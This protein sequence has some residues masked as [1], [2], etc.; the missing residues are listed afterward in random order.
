[1]ARR[2]CRGRNMGAHAG[3]RPLP[4]R[5]DVAVIAV[6]VVAVGVGVTTKD[7]TTSAG[8]SKWWIFWA[9]AIYCVRNDVSA[10]KQHYQGGTLRR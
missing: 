7:T 3:G 9:K 4:P 6:V 8:I 5:I 10:D 2:G 1:M